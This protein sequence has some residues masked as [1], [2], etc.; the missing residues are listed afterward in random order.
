[1][2]SD[3]RFDRQNLAQLILFRAS[4]FGFRISLRPGRRASSPGQ[5]QPK[6]SGYP[7]KGIE[8]QNEE[9]GQSSE[10][11]TQEAFM[12]L[13]GKHHKELNQGRAEAQ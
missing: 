12:G 3:L 4:D 7:P 6:G 1:L 9:G 13:K 11:Q 8:N 10:I 2:T 5:F